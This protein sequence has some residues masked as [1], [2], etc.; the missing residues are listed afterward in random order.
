MADNLDRLHKTINDLRTPVPTGSRDCAG[1]RCTRRVSDNAD[2]GL[3]YRCLEDLQQRER[4][5]ALGVVLPSPSSNLILP[6]R[7]L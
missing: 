4:L 1:Y 6:G 2:R 3:C 7:L 5:E